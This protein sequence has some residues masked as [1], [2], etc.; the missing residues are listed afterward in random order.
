MACLNASL[1]IVIVVSATLLISIAD[2]LLAAP[3]P[4]NLALGKKYTLKPSPRYSY[5]TDPDDRV[6]LTDG[7]YTKGYFWTQKTTVG[8][9]YAVPA[10]ITVDLGQVEPINGVSYNT[11]AGVAGVGWPDSI[12]ILTSDDGKTYY[13]AGELVGLDA[14]HG[15]L[16]KSGYGVRRYWTDQLKTRGRFVTFMISTSGPYTFV[17]EVEVYRGND[18]LVNRTRTGKPVGNPDTFYKNAVISNSF[19]RRIRDDLTA[20]LESA[21]ATVQIELSAIGAELAKTNFTMPEGFRSILPLNDL[22]RR[23]FA[24]QARLWREQFPR[25]I[26]LWQKPQW[27]MVSPTE[28]PRPGKAKVDVA[29]MRNEFRSAAF[30]LSNT[31][32]AAIDVQLRLVGL[33]RDG[34][35]VDVHEGVFTD[36]KTGVP[37]IA[38]LPYAKRKAA[39]ASM[40][41]EAGMHKQVWLTFNSKDVA[42]GQYD[43]QIVVE[44]GGGTVPVSLHVYPFDFPD[45][46]TLHLG[47]WDY[48]DSTHRDVT[49][50]NRELLVRHLREHFVETP[51]ATSGVLDKGR[52]DKAGNMITPPSTDRFRDWVGRWPNARIYAVFVALSPS[53]GDLQEGTPEFRKAVAAWITWWA[54][55]VQEFGIKPSQLAVLLVDEPHMLEQDTTIVEYARVIQQAAP[56]VIVWEDPTWRRPSDALPELFTQSDVLCPNLPMWIAQGK[57][58]ADFYVKQRDAGRKLWFYSCSGPG[59]LLDPYSYHRMQHWFCWKYDAQGSCF[60]A[61]GDSS[62]ASTWNEY[63]AD[64]AAYTP[65][66]LDATSVTPG[67]HMEAIREG[68]EDYEYLHIL[69]DRITQVEK[70]ADAKTVGAAK[71]LLATAADRVTACMDQQTKINWSEEKDRTVADAVRLELLGMLMRLK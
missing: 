17:D 42:A 15:R 22:H 2:V 19:K 4:A 45:Q 48:T 62:G 50:A 41:V 3:Q 58:F 25:P 43:G 8:W 9:Q 56:E 27:D 70:T 11:A 18:S 46:P 37:I 55:E 38:A 54:E 66:F 5:C 30:M 28:P 52:Y 64:R 39:T 33:P 61:F 44:P 69:R 34:A 1:R 53:F 51:W 35:C 12:F 21:P 68:M 71:Q 40:T 65:V 57:S 10:T 49:P 24:V 6:Q 13:L 60:W 32:D 20:V 23:V 26:T 36:T 67:K 59:K 47:G 31:S 7:V 16:S 63:L 29:M 14:V